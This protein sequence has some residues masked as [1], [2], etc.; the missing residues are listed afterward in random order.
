MTRFKHAVE[1]APIRTGHPRQAAS[2]SLA[3]TAVCQFLR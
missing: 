1:A 3:L 2:V